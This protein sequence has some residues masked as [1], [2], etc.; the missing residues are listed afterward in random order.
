M[1]AGGAGVLDSVVAWALALFLGQRAVTAGPVLVVASLAALGLAWPRL[2]AA[3][4]LGAPLWL[5]L[6]LARGTISLVAADDAR[7]AARDALGPPTRCTARARVVSSPVLKGGAF[8]WSAELSSVRCDER[9]LAGPVVARLYGDDPDVARG[10]TL[11]LV[12]SL[13]PAQ[14]FRN[15]DVADPRP[16]A[17]RAG[18]VA[19]GAIV[20]AERVARVAT[21]GSLVDRARRHVRAR[22]QAT[23]GPVAEPL[24]RALVLGEEDL[25]PDDE[26][27]FKQSGLAHLL[28]VSGTHL[29]LVV[30]GVVAALRAVFARVTAIAARV[31]AA[32]VASLLGVAL[33]FAY[34]DFAGG[35]GS[36]R[37][38][39]WMAAALLGARAL[40]RR[41]T[42]VRALGVS[43]LVLGMVDP[44]AAYD[45]SLALSAAATAGLLALAGPFADALAP[46]LARVP[47]L[48]RPLGASLAAFVACGPIVATLSPTLPLLGVAANLLAVPVGEAVALPACLL[49][50]LASPVPVLEQGAASVAA[51]ALLVVRLVARATAAAPLATVA[52]PAPTLAHAI[53]ALLVASAAARV[54]RRAGLVVLGASA[55]LVVEVAT[56]RLGRPRDRLRVTF[57]DVGQGDA[58]LVDLPDGRAMLVD[59]GGFVGSPVD[60]GTRVLLP[61][62][63]ARRR[64]RVDVAVLSHPHPDHFLGLST[65]LP[66]LE[67]GELWDT[68]QGEAEGAGATYAAM[69]AGLRSRAVPIVRP[70]A[71][72]GAPRAFGAARVEVLAPC[73][74]Y[75]PLG[76]ANDNSLV[77]RVSLGARAALLVG[78]A[79]HEAE[80]ALVHDGDPSRLRA[81]VL[82]LGHHGSR[83]STSPE[84]LAAVAPSLA[85][86]SCGVRNRFGH[87]HPTTL[88]TLERAR[89]PGARTD[90][91]GAVVWETDGDTVRVTRP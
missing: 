41:G 82:K 74:S 19:S 6:G 36:A 32:R 77:V 26:D 29:V 68:G 22:I 27:A 83:T 13:A 71:L 10:D 62:L 44:L 88:A 45:V 48:A 24:A 16:S 5:A 69:L 76:S 57:L 35:S 67:V 1:L 75:A 46:R 90:R 30:F 85:V 89:V 63:R 25:A 43:A 59:G 15:P 80:R 73:P 39:A 79:E 2:R 21:P 84:F 78:D 60:P 56:A 72:C 40:G 4:R 37:R 81:D 38:A 20:H 34:A 58:A 61:V 28:A 23:Y 65:A 49:A 47:Q 31:D 70:D 66:R 17:A 42:G 14:L 51:G 50:S 53:V 55:L 54:R 52:V 91:G 18:V 11:E 33:A 12:A 8:R 9:V 87:P 64:S 86:L 3:A 7:D